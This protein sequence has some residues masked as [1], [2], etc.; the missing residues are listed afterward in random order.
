MR[1]SRHAAGAATSQRRGRD[2]RR[3][4]DVIMSLGCAK[5]L[6]LGTDYVKTGVGK[7]DAG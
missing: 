3:E 7:R 5:T 4:A 1:A 2:I 6:D